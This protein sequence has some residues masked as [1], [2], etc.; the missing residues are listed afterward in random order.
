MPI[1]MKIIVVSQHYFLNIFTKNKTNYGMF[2]FIYY[3][4]N[5]YFSIFYIFIPQD[6]YFV[7]KWH[8]PEK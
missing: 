8:R 1:P 5:I 3:I 4:I 7:T 6:T 2:I